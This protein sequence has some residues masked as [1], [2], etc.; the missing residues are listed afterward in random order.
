MLTGVV[1]DLA[2]PNEVAVGVGKNNRLGALHVSPP[3]VVAEVN[4]SK[5][6]VGFAPAV[7]G[8]ALGALKA[9]P[10]GAV[11]VGT[12]GA[13]SGEIGLAAGG[14]NMLTAGAALAL[15]AGVDEGG[16]KLSRADAT[17]AI[18]WATGVADDDGTPTL[19]RVGTAG[20]E[21]E[22]DE[23]AAFA[24]AA[25]NMFGTVAAAAALGSAPGLGVWQ[26]PQ[27]SSASRLWL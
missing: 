9:N 25:A 19:N 23:E 14:A 3:V 6:P 16:P 2:E 21:F 26:A 27:L 22:D 15:E 1:V 4:P 20:F 5:L 7:A 8:V 12:E 17:G 13:A 18:G 10:P 11:T 24:I